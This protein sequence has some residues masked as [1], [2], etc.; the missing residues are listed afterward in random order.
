MK[1]ILI[2]AIGS[3][4]ALTGCAG[5]SMTGGGNGNDK[6]SVPYD[7]NKIGDPGAETPTQRQQEASYKSRLMD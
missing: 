3:V 4:L 2:L 7:N 5:Q 1:K 6:S